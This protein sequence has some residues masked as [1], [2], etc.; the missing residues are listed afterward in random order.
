MTQEA[1]A[2][3]LG[4]SR[5]TYTCYEIGNSMPTAP[6]LC[7]LADLFDVSL[8]YLLGRG[9]DPTRFDDKD[10]KRT[11][12]EIALLDCFRRINDEGRDAIYNMAE[13]LDSQ[14]RNRR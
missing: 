3:I 7:L 12:Q 9:E 14:Q 13:L 4:V 8:D 11:S 1:V 6:N 2:E 5:S 10:P